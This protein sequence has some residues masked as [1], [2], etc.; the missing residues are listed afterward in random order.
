MQ[1]LFRGH[2]AIFFGEQIPHIPKDLA[3]DS[4]ISL[5]CLQFHYDGATSTVFAKD[6]DKSC[7]HRSLNSVIDNA[8]FRIQCGYIAPQCHLHIPLKREL[9]LLLTRGLP[10]FKFTRRLDTIYVSFGLF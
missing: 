9:L 4:S 1:Q 8:Q 10:D 6:V 2:I 7:I 3:N 5:T